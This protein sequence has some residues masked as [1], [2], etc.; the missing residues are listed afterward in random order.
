MALVRCGAKPPWAGALQSG[1]FSRHQA[2]ASRK[3]RFYLGVPATCEKVCKEAGNRWYLLTC[4]LVLLLQGESLCREDG[5][6]SALDV[7]GVMGSD[8]TA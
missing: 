7:L 1:S 8:P 2:R 4:W 6:V 5:A 3:L